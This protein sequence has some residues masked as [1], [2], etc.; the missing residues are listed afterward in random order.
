V[1]VALA[2]TQGAK[3]PSST[4]SPLASGATHKI[5]LRVPVIVPVIVS[6]TVVAAVA[7]ARIE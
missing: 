4:P 7:F 1:F 3:I 5:E 2:G 6:V